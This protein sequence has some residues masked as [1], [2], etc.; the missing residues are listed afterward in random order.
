MWD[1]AW[2]LSH[3]CRRPSQQPKFEEGICC[4]SFRSA[5]SQCF[6]FLLSLYSR[7]FPSPKLP[8]K[9][10]E[11]LIFTRVLFFFLFC[12]GCDVLLNNSENNKQK[13]KFTG[14][15]RVF[16]C[17][18]FLSSLLEAILWVVRSPEGEEIRNVAAQ[19]YLLN[20]RLRCHF[21]CANRN[22][23]SVLVHYILSLAWNKQSGKP[24]V[25][26]FWWF[27]FSSMIVISRG[28]FH[29][30]VIFSPTLGVVLACWIWL[31]FCRIIWNPNLRL[32]TQILLFIRGGGGC[33]QIF[34]ASAE[35]CC[36]ESSFWNKEENRK[37]NMGSAASTSK[38]SK[39]E[40]V[41]SIVSQAA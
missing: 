36:C 30:D 40:N 18:L 26:D 7:E 5:E 22:P 24:P 15:V 1:P 20:D 12:S 3:K 10:Y 41:S 17:F 34:V 8:K 37:T 16:S 13:S 33:S 31:N 2:H 21:C 4:V 6:R 19:T 28:K 38:G 35:A 11:D 32:P 29:K 14:V 27:L 23:G 9:N 39:F 25:K